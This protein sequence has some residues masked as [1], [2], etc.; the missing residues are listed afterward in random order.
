MRLFNAGVYLLLLGLTFEAWEGGIKKDPSTY[1]YYFVT[2]GLAFFMLIGLYGLQEL[3]QTKFIIE[4]LSLNGRN[5]MVAYVAGSLL[6]LP[7]LNLTGGIRVL[8]SM[9]TDPWT[10]FLRGVLFT[11]IVS[12]ITIYFTQK[13]WFWKT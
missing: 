13:K 7:L 11:G 12:L 6:L 8:E 5:P 2:T 9:N 1:S 4:Y 3:R 10:G